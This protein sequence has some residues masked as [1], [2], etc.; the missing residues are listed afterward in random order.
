MAHHA[1]R[2][3]TWYCEQCST[4][5]DDVS[6]GE[7]E[8]DARDEGGRGSMALKQRSRQLLGLRPSARLWGMQV[9][10][11]LRASFSTAAAAAA[12]GS[13]AVHT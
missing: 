8:E 13:R 6:P 4:R 9:P 2:A 7:E 12:L 3:W 5:D 1:R 10:K 11:S